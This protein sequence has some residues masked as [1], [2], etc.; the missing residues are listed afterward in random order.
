MAPCITSWLGMY[1]A[2]AWVRGDDFMRNG[3]YGTMFCENYVIGGRDGND[4]ESG[5]APHCYI[6]PL[7]SR[8][9]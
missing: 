2:I 7:Q 1:A 8:Y 9:T 4:Q 6:C 5:L 3:G